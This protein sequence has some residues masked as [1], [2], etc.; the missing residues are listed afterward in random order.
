MPRKV[1]VEVVERNP[2]G[3]EIDPAYLEDQSTDITEMPG[4]SNL[5]R[6]RDAAV[7]KGGK[8]P[9]L[10]GRLHWAR[11]Q[12]IGGQADN[13]KVAE[14]K[15]KGYRVIQWEEAKALG[16]DVEASAAQRGTDGTI[17]LN[18]Y[19][20]MWAPPEVAA[21]RYKAQRKATTSQYEDVV[22]P[23]LDA[24][25]ARAKAAGMDDQEFSLEVS[26]SGEGKRKAK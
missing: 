2:F 6:Q 9:A 17:R 14:W 1:I 20:A 3:E 8:V 4:Y 13:R 11:A 16:L 5:R 15:T 7:Q 18:E 21:A 24:A 25:A 26:P 10:P 19:V 22:Q 12:T 23:K